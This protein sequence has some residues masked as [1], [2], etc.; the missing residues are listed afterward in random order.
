MVDVPTQ[1]LRRVGAAALL[2]AV[3]AGCS[4]P[5]QAPTTRRSDATP[6]ASVD[7]RIVGAEIDERIQAHFD[8]SPDAFKNVRAVLVTVDGRPVLERYFGSS[9]DD[10]SDTLSVTKSVMS[11]LIGIALD[12]GLIDSVDQT[13]VELL[14]THAAD[15]A[16]ASRAVTLRQVLTMTGG[17][18][19]Q[20]YDV[21]PDAW[22]RA[23]DPTRRIL[24][25]GPVQ[26]SEP[27][28]SYSNAG[29]HLLSVIVAE[30]TGRS[31]LDYARE[32]LF[33][34][35]GI[36][37]EPAVEPVVTGDVI[38]G[39]DE[40]AFAW[41][42]DAQGY[43][44]GD[45]CIKLSARDMAKLGQLMLDDGRW[46]GAQIVSAEWVRTSTRPQVP[47]G[48]A[49]EH[50]GYQWWVTEADGHP[51]YAAVGRYG[52]LVE[53]VPPLDL[54]V[55]VSSVAAPGNAGDS[56][57]SMVSYVVAPAFRSQ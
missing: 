14:P 30:A 54:V 31:T 10:T 15:M 11:I 28:F 6:I 46:Q 48:G 9:A 25:D 53:V 49:A 3:L 16:A 34:P 32:K 36:D 17:F 35:L 26:V 47:A 37:T 1:R 18:P 27:D 22:F 20:S 23:D 51:A 52:Q 41:P 13:L 2:L 19:P 5:A 33:T 42:R 55:V 29:S 4:G 40:A 38:P 8:N 7:P 57:V 12:E 21:G 43:H 24:S 39:Y 44:F 50:Y 45:C 56:M